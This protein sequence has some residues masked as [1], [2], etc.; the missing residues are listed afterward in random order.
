M[1]SA[2]AGRTFRATV[3]WR[4]DQGLAHA[5]TRFLPT[6]ALFPGYV[7]TRHRHAA[8]TTAFL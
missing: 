1:L 3:A 7:E 5:G 2:A 6:N 8:C 4:L